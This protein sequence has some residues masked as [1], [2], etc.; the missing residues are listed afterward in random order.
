MNLRS[1]LCHLLSSD[2]NVAPIGRF[3]AREVCGVDA[4]DVVA[5][6]QLRSVPTRLRGA[7]VAHDVRHFVEEFR[8]LAAIDGYAARVRVGDLRRVAAGRQAR[9]LDVYM[10]RVEA[11]RGCAIRFEQLIAESV[12]TETAARL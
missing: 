11:G 6:G 7:P 5:R 2:Q 12:E 4:Q 9:K 8:L 3:V 1:A 10:R